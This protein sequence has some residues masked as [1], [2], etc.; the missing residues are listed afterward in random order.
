[1]EHMQDMTRMHFLFKNLSI[2]KTTDMF[3][4]NNTLRNACTIK[5]DSSSSSGYSN[6]NST[7]T[8]EVDL[9]T[10]TTISATPTSTITTTT[11]LDVTSSED[12][13]K[14]RKVVRFADEPQPL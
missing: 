7:T 6:S 3:I 10:T 1:M 9:N 14:K 8:E 13:A 11:L 12:G 4:T 2:V 5:N